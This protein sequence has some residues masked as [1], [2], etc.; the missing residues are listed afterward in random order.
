MSSVTFTNGVPSPVTSGDSKWS[1]TIV[2][3]LSGKQDKLT[4]GSNITISGS[5]ISAKDTTYTF[6]ASDPTLA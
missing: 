1:D 6:T 2:N 3:D 4:A 5:K